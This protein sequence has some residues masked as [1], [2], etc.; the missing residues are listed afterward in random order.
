[1]S[2]DLLGACKTQ[3]KNIGN[4]NVNNLALYFYQNS[5]L[6]GVRRTRTA[7]FAL[8]RHQQSEMHIVSDSTTMYLH[9]VTRKISLEVAPTTLAQNSTNSQAVTV[10]CACLVLPSADSECI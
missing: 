5:R 2:H 1:M 4:E 7:E 10:L 3:E 6:P 8:H 9:L